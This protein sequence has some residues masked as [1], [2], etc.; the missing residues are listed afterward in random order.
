MS[1]E[2][3]PGGAGLRSAS[4]TANRDH[5]EVRWL[6]Q[7]HFTFTRSDSTVIH[8]DPFLSRTVK[9]ENHFRPEP[10]MAPGDAKADLVL[11][12]HDHRDHTDP[13]TIAPM[14]EANPECLFVGTDAS[15]DRC[16]ALGVEESRL[17]RVRPGD[18]IE[19][20]GVPVSVVYAEKTGDEDDTIHLGFILS[21]A[22]ASAV[23]SPSPAA[24]GRRRVYITGDTRN[25][26]GAYRDR[27]AAVE[28]LAPDLLIVPINEGYR[29]PGPEGAR[30]LVEITDP[31]MIIPCHFA[32]FRN[33]TIDPARFVELLPERYRRRVR[34]LEP[35]ESFLWPLDFS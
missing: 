30:E 6:E 35:G 33:N 26:V 28:G 32:C 8:V 10:F 12:T 14:A 31:A 27:L 3:P 25:G 17:R 19:P 11:L 13:D 22:V 5:I 34:I 16:A 18:V 1:N 15:C 4:D 7:S 20:L 9:P 24:T 21:F 23:G 29:N 2:L